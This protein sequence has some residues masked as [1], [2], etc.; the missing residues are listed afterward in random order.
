MAAVAAAA[1]VARSITSVGHETQVIFD[2]GSF[3]AL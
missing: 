3:Y 1:N 2:V